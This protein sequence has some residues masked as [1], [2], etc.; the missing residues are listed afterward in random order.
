MKKS[1]RFLIPLAVFALLLVFLLIGLRLNPREVPSPLIDK[2]APAFKLPT[3]REPDRRIGR[4]DLLGQPYVL[5]V[6]ASWCVP[7]QVEHPFVTD[8]AKTKLAPVYAL[9]YKD[10]R[11]DATAWL[12][13]FGDP[14]TAVL[15]DVDGRTGIDFG[16]YGVPETFVIDRKGVIRF[17]H[18]G[19]LLPD[20]ARKQIV[21]LLRKLQEET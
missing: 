21:P 10:K 2:P 20:T 14:F 3:L 4:D 7:C 13:R 11:E 8:I 18:I 17:K 12:A 16:V 15:V 5:N 6:F 9:N 19:P 1:L